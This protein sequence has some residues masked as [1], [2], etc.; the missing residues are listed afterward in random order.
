MGQL[1]HKNGQCQFGLFYLGKYLGSKNESEE[2]YK[3]LCLE[4]EYHLKS[5]IKDFGIG[6]Q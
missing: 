6:D 1:K 5:T 2:K 4:S 3:E